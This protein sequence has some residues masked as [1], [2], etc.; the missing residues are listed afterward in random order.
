[1]NNRERP[2]EL[3][4]VQRALARHH[5]ITDERL[6]KKKEKGGVKIGEGEHNI[7]NDLRFADDTFLVAR[8]LPQLSKMIEYHTKVQLN[9]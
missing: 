9:M 6:K 7:A 3:L 4:A 5:G 8:T 2:A 1:M